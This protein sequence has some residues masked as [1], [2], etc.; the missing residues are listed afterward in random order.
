VLTLD[1]NSIEIKR[2]FIKSYIFSYLYLSPDSTAQE[3]FEYLNPHVNNT[4]HK[5]FIDKELNNLRIKQSLVSLVDKKKFRLSQEMQFQISQI[6][7]NVLEQEKTLQEMIVSFLAANNIP[8]DANELTSLIYKLYQENYTIDI[9]EL[10]N[11]N[12]SFS[13]SIKK[14]FNDLVYY[15]TR[16]DVEYERSKTIS[17]HLL[18]LCASNEFLNKLS[19]IHLFTNLYSSNKLEKYVN[20][21]VQDVL[22]D[23]QILIRMICVLYSG[24][25]EYSDSALESVKILVSTF[26]KFKTK[27]RLI[28]THDYVGEV[29]GHLYDAFK[30]QRFVSL[31]FFS[32]LGKSKNVF[33]NTFQELKEKDY[34]DTELDFGE[35]VN[36]LINEEILLE[37]ENEALAIISRKLTEILEL[38]NIELLYH[39]AYANYLSLKREYEISLAYKS[40]IRTYKAR[41]NDLRTILYLS[42]KENHINSEN[43]EINEPFLITWDGAFYDFRKELIK[44]HKELSFWYI[45]SPLKFVDRLSVMNFTLN[46]KSISLNIVALTETNFNY[47]AKTSSFIDIISNFFNTKDVSKLSIINRLAD[48]KAQ[49]RNLEEE[50]AVDEFKDSEESPVTTLLLNLQRHYY[51]YESKYKFEDIINIFELPKYET[52]IIQI[53]QHYLKHFSPSIELTNMY[54][55][56]DALI[57][58]SKESK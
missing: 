21:K 58:E 42:T 41:E 50:H 7:A 25:F 54:E 57:T 31:S 8:S 12:N 13:A 49:T 15:F 2:N 19:S 1:S 53:L 10:K 3:I 37:N 39:P 16:K 34:W 32:K 46:P 48:L 51:S 56:F 5:D 44:N 36:E 9:E 14:C 38:A 35:F 11:T 55:Q 23:T 45:Y 40:R 43:G 52:P 33:Y 29:A 18:K 28:T 6:Y 20:N 22:L 26:E 47:S 27:I 30:L 4:L 17:K 24:K